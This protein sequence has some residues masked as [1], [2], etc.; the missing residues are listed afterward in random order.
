[1][2]KFDNRMRTAIVRFG[3]HKDKRVRIVQQTGT[4]RVDGKPMYQV[5]FPDGQ[6]RTYHEDEL[7]LELE[8]DKE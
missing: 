7:E 2:L 8:M 1:M 5:L 6:V 4:S 3:M